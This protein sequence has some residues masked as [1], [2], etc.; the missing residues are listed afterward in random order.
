MAQNTAAD[1][2]TDHMKQMMAEHFAEMESEYRDG[3][4]CSVVYED[5]EVVLIA[6]HKG[7]EFGEWRDEFDLADGRFSEIMHELAGQLT[8]RRWA[9]DYPVVFDKLKG[10]ND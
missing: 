5:D 6:D 1:G 10:G 4:W 9:S 8:D 3:D 7:Y 2:R